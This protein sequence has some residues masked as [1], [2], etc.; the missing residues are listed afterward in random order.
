M[1]VKN[2]SD[3]KLFIIYLKSL[4]SKFKFYIY[5]IVDSNIEGKVVALT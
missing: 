3:K 4:K 1:I 5:I 2:N